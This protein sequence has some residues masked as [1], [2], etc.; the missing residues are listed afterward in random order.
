MLCLY[1]LDD[2]GKCAGAIVNYY[3]VHDEFEDKFVKINYGQS[4]PWD[5][6]QKQEFVYI[7]D[8][9]IEPEDMKKL[10]NITSNVIWI[11]HH[12]TAIA[13]YE[14]FDQE[15]SGIRSTVCS[16]CMLTYLYLTNQLN[17]I[18]HA[19]KGDTASCVPEI[20][21]Y[22]DDYDMWTFRCDR[23]KEFHLGFSII[24]HE[25]T[26]DVWN[27]FFGS[28]EMQDIDV[29]DIIDKGQIMLQYRSNLMQELIESY[30][31]ESTLDGHSC[32]VLN[33]GLISSDDF[34]SIDVD[35]YDL[36]VGTIWDGDKWIYSLRST[37]INVA[38]IAVSRGGGGHPE[39]S[40]FIS[41]QLLV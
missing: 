6:I 8:F 32:Y 36:L 9:S 39:A 4:L 40:G 24:P 15:V 11:D 38:E 14:D 34:D 18:S 1:H 17:L 25:P 31:Y 21:R 29:D 16:G 35:K 28:E 30:G 22:C 20:I 33:Q 7:V 19:E 13:K 12:G 27:E 10:L 5:K 3:G 41:K 23:T 2:D 37:K 26:D